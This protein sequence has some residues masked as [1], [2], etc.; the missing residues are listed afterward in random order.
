MFCVNCGS[1]LTAGAGGTAAA[2]P[3]Y[4]GAMPG[5]PSAM[6]SERRKQI[7]RTKTGV[8][9]LLIGTL[10]AWLPLIG[11][12]G[13][14]LLLVGAILVILGRKAFGAAHARKVMI[15]I[16]LFFVGLII[17]VVAGI[18]LASA[19]LT[20]LFGGTPSQAGVQSALN[21][22]LIVAFVG[23]VVSGLASVFFTYEL[24]NKTGRYLL[25][26]GYA[27]TV[28]IQIAIIVIV[29]QTIA[30]ML[31][32]MFPGGTYNPTAGVAAL[33]NFTSQVQS[34]ALL[35]GIP[36]LIY[37]AADYLVWQRINKGEIPPAT[38]AP[39]MGPAPMPPR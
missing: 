13:A 1:A 30:A 9:L 2:P 5:L 7:D 23:T 21:N 20:G 28:V 22:Y 37:A 18:I 32:T 25:F 17:G 19:L 24:Q 34:V 26:A 27:A 3:M 29:G 10:I 38:T 4:P 8:L 31:A 6:D 16:V 14:I 36:A 15:S 35:S 39:P 12:I 11:I 33:A